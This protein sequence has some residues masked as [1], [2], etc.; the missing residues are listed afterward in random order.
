M[1]PCNLTVCGL[2][3]WMVILFTQQELLFCIQNH[4]ECWLLKTLSYSKQ[5]LWLVPWIPGLA[6]TSTIRLFQQI[7]K[8]EAEAGPQLR[9]KALTRH[10]QSPGSDPQHQRANP[11]Q[12]QR[13]W[14]NPDKLFT[15]SITCLCP[16]SFSHSLVWRWFQGKQSP[17][18]CVHPSLLLHISFPARPECME[19]LLETK[20]QC[21]LS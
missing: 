3:Y 13:G 7:A 5:G 11:E 4:L 6:H 16:L 15:K 1:I 17:K 14:R 18:E 12:S 9:G 2:P 20:N 21:H 10:M 19:M 8:S